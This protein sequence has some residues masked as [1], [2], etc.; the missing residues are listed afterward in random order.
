MRARVALLGVGTVGSALL[1]RLDRHGD[2]VDV[3]LVS[4]SR[5]CLI[6]SSGIDVRTAVAKLRTSEVASDLALVSPAIGASDVPRVVVDATASHAVAARHAHWLV[7]GIHVVT[8]SKIANGGGQTDADALA[9]AARVGGSTYGD[10]ATV[11][12]GLPVLRAIEAL[13]AGGDEITK[14]TGVLSGTLAWLLD[15]YETAEGRRPLADLV[16]EAHGLGLTEPDP[17]V[18]LSGTDVQRKLLVL[19]RAAGARLDPSDID[20]SPLV[21]DDFAPR[22]AAA[23]A[24]G[25]RLRYVASWAPGKRPTVGLTALPLGDP[26]AGGSGCDNRVAI[27]STRYRSSPLIVQGPGAG[28]EVTAAALMDDVLRASAA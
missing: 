22:V 28:G 11:G 17:Q 13:R 26:L 19:A 18:D 5:Q 6:D 3:I 4:S 25:R 7:R 21:P 27:W 14:I 2:G 10:S 8:A 9:A 1:E 23:A 20:V 12:A 15:A 24:D 16:D